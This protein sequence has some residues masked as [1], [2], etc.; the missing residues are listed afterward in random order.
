[1]EMF[2]DGK[3]TLK[4]YLLDLQSCYITAPVRKQYLVNVFGA[5]GED[6]LA[7]GLGPARYETRTVTAKFL[8]AVSGGRGLVSALLHELEGRTVQI[9]LPDDPEHYMTGCVHVASAGIGDSGEITITARCLPWRY[10]ATECVCVCPASESDAEYT[11]YNSGGREAVPT[12]TVSADARI[13]MDGVSLALS[14]GTYLLTELTIPGGESISFQVSG[15][16]V[17]LRF[18]EAVL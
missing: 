1:M 4:D 7:D 5:D 9:V 18:R 2:F 6:D 10:A 11:L 12:V 3:S 16:P 15:G 13:T 17:E 14:A 8:P